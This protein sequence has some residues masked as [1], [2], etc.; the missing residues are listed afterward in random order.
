MSISGTHYVITS[1]VI[2]K[3]LLPKYLLIIDIIVHNSPCVCI[4]DMYKSIVIM[5][6]GLQRFE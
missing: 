6:G 5:Y 4:D 3:I 2:K 1:E